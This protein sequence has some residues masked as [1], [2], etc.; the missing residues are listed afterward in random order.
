MPLHIQKAQARFA[1]VA[2]MLQ[3]LAV[4]REEFGTEIDGIACDLTMTDDGQ[5]SGNL[6]AL[7]GDIEVQGGAL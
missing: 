1:L 6:S 4:F 5:F 7:S 2:A 3:T